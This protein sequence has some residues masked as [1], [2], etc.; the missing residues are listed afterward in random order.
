VGRQ[1]A[2]IAHMSRRSFLRVFQSATGTAPLAWL[3]DICRN[4]PWRIVL[5]VVVDF[6]SAMTPLPRKTSCP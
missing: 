4:Y 6:S 3:I 2:S 5:S 1:L